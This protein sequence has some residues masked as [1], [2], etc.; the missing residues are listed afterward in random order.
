MRLTIKIFLMSTAI[1]FGGY[2]GW[3]I[4]QPNLTG[5][6]HIVKEDLGE[7]YS[8]HDWMETLDIT[9][10]NIVHLNYDFNNPNPLAGKVNR[11]YR[12]L[13]IGPSCLSLTANYFPEGNT[14]YIEIENHRE[15]F[16]PI[17][18]TAVKWVKCHH[19]W[20]PEK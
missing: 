5:H 4:W 13:Y 12:S 17:R 20:K 14:L 9:S 11:L 2:L 1:T 18:L 16:K 8:S 7:N 10:D 3:R 15:P 6:W 19:S